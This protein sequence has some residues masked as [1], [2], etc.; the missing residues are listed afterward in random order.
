MPEI[1]QTGKILLRVG[2]VSEGQTIMPAHPERAVL[3]LHDPYGV[4]LTM[5]LNRETGMI[6]RVTAYR[7]PADTNRAVTVHWELKE[8]R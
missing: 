8:F 6:E 5:E 2:V 3:Y 7:D 1:H 4:S